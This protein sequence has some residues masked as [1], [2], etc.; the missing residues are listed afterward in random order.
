[1]EQNI[2]QGSENKL[3]IKT[4]I[5][6]YWMIAIGLGSILGY[7]SKELIFFPYLVFVMSWIFFYFGLLILEG[8][9]WAWKLGIA[10]LAIGILIGLMQAVTYLGIDFENNILISIFIFTVPFILLISDREN[11]WKITISISDL[12]ERK[13]VKTKI[14]AWTVFFLG[15][16]IIKFAISVFKIQCTDMGCFGNFLVFVIFGFIGLLTII[17]SMVI[18]P[19]PPK[20]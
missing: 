14:V 20:K 5:A 16:F 1:M 10:T 7:L 12:V 6:A 3:P 9:K 19:R 15:L 18:Y 8:K 4:K 17:M 13:P 11:F 2:Q